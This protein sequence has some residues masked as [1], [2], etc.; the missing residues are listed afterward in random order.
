MANEQ[1]ARVSRAEENQAQRRRRQPGTIDRMD[2]F[3]LT[4]PDEVQAAN[5]DHVFRWVLDRPKRMHQLTV[6]DDWDRVDG[7][8]PIPD[9]ADKAG[10]QLNLVLVKKRKEFWEEDQ[11]AKGQALREQE[12]AMVR[13]AS[14]DP[15]DD[16]PADVSYVPD[17][18]SITSGFTP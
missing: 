13:K 12:Q 6:R 1:R 10:N 7:V 15:Q 4:I 18:N 5:P 16:R 9:H 3:A 2:E 11:R 17:G 14:N 8:E